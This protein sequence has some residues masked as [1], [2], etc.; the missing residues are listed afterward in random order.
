MNRILWQIWLGLGNCCCADRHFPLY[1]RHHAVI[2]LYRYFGEEL[3]NA[4]AMNLISQSFPAR[5]VHQ[6]PRFCTALWMKLV[7][8]DV[9]ALLLTPSTAWP[10]GQTSGPRNE[11]CCNIEHCCWWACCD[12]GGRTCGILPERALHDEWRSDSSIGDHTCHLPRHTRAKQKSTVVMPRN[13]ALYM[14]HWHAA[15]GAQA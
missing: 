10:P 7:I 12:H 9:G 15:P 5:C 1:H 6:L 13:W 4:L 14:G 3:A 8:V 2:Y 11:H